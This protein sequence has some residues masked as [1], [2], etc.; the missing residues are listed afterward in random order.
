M[1]YITKKK[2][3]R[4]ALSVLMLLLMLTACGT[5]D[6]AVKAPI[7]DE[8]L[9]E[10]QL[11]EGG[12]IENSVPS[13]RAQAEIDKEAEEAA[14]KKSPYPVLKDIVPPGPLA[15]V[16]LRDGTMY[17]IIKFEKLGKYYIYI[18]GKL[19]GRAAT[20]MSLT[21]FQDL[22]HWTEI[23]FQ[24]RYN[25]IISTSSGKN[26]RFLNS[27]VYLGTDSHDT[28]SFYVA[29]GI[30]DMRVE[31]KKDDVASIFIAQPAP[32]GQ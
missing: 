4:T 11:A 6:E 32:E 12:N 25:F 1:M 2:S 16:R 17:E 7:D 14:K 18:S 10:E 13:P 21:R 3:M 19:N 23:S 28:F 31:V 30:K 22:Q 8:A 29:D 5:K 9:T 24:D 15:A 20:V 26:L 27:R